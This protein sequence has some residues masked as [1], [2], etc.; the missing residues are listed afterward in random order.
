MTIDYDLR[1]AHPADFPRLSALMG[2]AFQRDPVS[3]W[4]FPNDTDRAVRHPAFF[5]VF[6]EQALLHGSVLR[7]VD[8]RAVALWLKVDAPEPVPDSGRMPDAL[9]E[10]CG[11]N[12]DRFETLGRL[13]GEHHPKPVPH[14]YLTFIAVAPEVWGQGLGT[15]LLRHKLAQLDLAG[16][17]AYLEASSMRSRGLYERHGFEA[18]DRQISLPD[19]P[20]LYPMWR[21]AGAP[22]AIPSRVNGKSF[23]ARGGS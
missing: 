17:P 13:M 1:Y 14:A 9:I 22:V 16:M 4:L 20:S 21:P 23:D 6:L 15:A 8:F 10:A 12:Y 7:T 3:Q 2:S 18:G 5:A 11:P 19:G